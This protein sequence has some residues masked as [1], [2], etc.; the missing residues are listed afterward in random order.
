MEADEEGS[1]LMGFCRMY[2]V[3]FRVSRLPEHSCW[4]SLHRVVL[5]LPVVPGPCLC[6]QRCPLGFLPSCNGIALSFQSSCRVRLL[7][8][9]CAQQSWID[10]H[11]LR[12][13]V[14][15]CFGGFDQLDNKIF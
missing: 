5:N 10:M 4:V 12:E 9:L 14:P 1:G 15:H 3:D 8:Y 13:L 6:S 2:R 11:L 7:V